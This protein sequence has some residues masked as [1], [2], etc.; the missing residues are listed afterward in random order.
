MKRIVFLIT[1]ILVLFGAVSYS[2]TLVIYFSCTGS[3]EKI[4]S[5]AADVAGADLYRILPSV[6][7]TEDDLEY[8]TD[9]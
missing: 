6:P 8:Y 4:A 7:Y 2:E 3:T 1:F 9:W 5:I